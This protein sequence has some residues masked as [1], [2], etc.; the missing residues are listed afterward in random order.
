MIF[1]PINTKTNPTV[2]SLSA[3]PFTPSINNV[4]KSSFLQPSQFKLPISLTTTPPPVKKNWS[5]KKK[6][7]KNKKWQNKLELNVMVVLLF[8]SCGLLP[9]APFW[10]LFFIACFSLLFISSL[11]LNSVKKNKN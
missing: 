2:V 3:A 5:K 8:I 9:F 10:I 7:Y 11:A 6:L 4:V 1:E